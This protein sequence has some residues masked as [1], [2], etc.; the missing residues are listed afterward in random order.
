MTIDANMAIGF[1]YGFSVGSIF[2]MVMTGMVCFF[3]WK[4][5]EK[6]KNGK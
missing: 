1:Q 4:N 2:G 6:D 3:V 5:V